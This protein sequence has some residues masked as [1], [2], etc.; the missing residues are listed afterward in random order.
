MVRRG[1]ECGLEEI[2]VVGRLIADSEAA[3]LSRQRAADS[4]KNILAADSIGRFPDQNAADALGRVSGISIE[5]D[6]G[7]ARF[8]NVRRAPAE[9]SN[10]AFNG[11]AAPTPSQGG[12]LRVSTRLPTTLSSLSK[13]KRP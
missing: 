4:V 11:V 2:R 5:R 7:Q 8:V 10:I 1:V 9:F 13:F 3:A 6:Q 12:A